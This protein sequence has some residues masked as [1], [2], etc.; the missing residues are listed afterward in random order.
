MATVRINFKRTED[1]N[2]KEY[3]S[4]LKKDQQKYSAKRR[5]TVYEIVPKKEDRQKNAV[6]RGEISIHLH[7][8]LVHELMS[9][10]YALWVEGNRERRDENEKKEGERERYSVF[11]KRTSPHEIKTIR[12][13]YVLVRPQYESSEV[14]EAVITKVDTKGLFVLEQLHPRRH[15]HHSLVRRFK[16]LH[17]PRGQY[18]VRFLLNRYDFEN[19]HAALGSHLPRMFPEYA[20]CPK[21]ASKQILS[22]FNKEIEKNEE[23]KNAVWRIA[24]GAGSEAPFLL[25]GPPGTGKTATLVEAVLQVVAASAAHRV[26][27]CAPSNAAA[28][29]VA[30]LLV[31]AVST[32]ASALV[33]ASK[34]FLFR[35]NSLNRDWDVMPPELFKHSNKCDERA[36]SKKLMEYRVVVTTLLH[37]ACYTSKPKKP[38]LV[39]THVFVDEAAQAPEPACL[40]PLNLLTRHGCLVLCGDTKQLGPVCISHKAKLHGLVK[41]FG[42]GYDTIS[43]YI[44]ASP[45]VEGR[46]SRYSRAPPGGELRQ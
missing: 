35:A 46:K 41:R 23:Q 16:E 10:Y 11:E 44:A 20:L 34:K 6:K 37:A 26:L 1:L 9:I 33:P 30:C 39:V 42:Y 4:D 31:R 21:F 32:S 7:H 18:E 40:V 29:H 15:S 13:A 3:K 5:T 38:G 19:M 28:D 25:V 12:G 36:N 17:K 45:G 24:A 22:Y 43:W 27:V 8:V 14:F 2:A